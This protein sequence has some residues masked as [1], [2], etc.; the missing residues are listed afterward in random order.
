MIF[1]FDLKDVKMG[2]QVLIVMVITT[3]TSFITVTM[4]NRLYKY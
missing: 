1:D 2:N 4:C 3:A